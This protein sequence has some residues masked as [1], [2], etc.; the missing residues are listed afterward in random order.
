LEAG[1]TDIFMK[2]DWELAWLFEKRM[3]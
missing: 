2:K 1:Y 3:I